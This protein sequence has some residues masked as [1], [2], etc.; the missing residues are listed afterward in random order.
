M[1]WILLL[2]VA[3]IAGVGLLNLRSAAEVAGNSFHLTQLTRMLLGVGVAG[4][5]ASQDYRLGARWAYV[6]LG[7]VVFLLL[8]V[9]PLGTTLNNSRRWLDLG[10]FLLQPSELMKVAVI[11]V[12]ARYLHDHEA[13]KGRSLFQLFVPA[14]LCLGPCLLVMMQ[15]DLGTALVI[16]FIFGTMC[17]FDGIR[18]TTLVAML[19]G[20]IIAAP[21]M[22][23]FGM[24]DYQKDRV[25][26]FLNPDENLQGDAYQVNQS[27]IAIGS[28][29]LFGK[30]Y[31]Q[32]TQVQNGFVPE[33]E[34]DFIFA[35][36]GEQ[37]GF[38][39]SIGLL[40]LYFALIV[41][42]LRI[43]RWGRDRFAV[44]CGVGVA[45]FFFW[46]VLVNLGMV[47][48]LLPVVGL[49]LP[50]ASYGGS[51]VLAVSCAVGLLLSI[52]MRR[53]GR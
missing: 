16:I 14:A 22:W 6:I 29:R 20:L 5:I 48:G 13:P 52:S 39:G 1:D 3:A 8:A 24:R 34:N 12:T 11:I 37:F 15:P 31:L 18:K 32:G 40:G 41:W 23:Q 33:H 10:V 28:G 47:T 42:S 25:V 19:V 51:S 17:L 44:L 45:S 38:A 43:A 30:G 26:A 21:L 4:L 9:F 53:I 2:L 46:H 49:W 35:H 7:A 36:H 27:K 50:L